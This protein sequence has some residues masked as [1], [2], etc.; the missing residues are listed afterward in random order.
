MR[1]HLLAA[2]AAVDAV[3]AG[4]GRA[5]DFEGQHLDFKEE[6]GTVR[7]GGRRVPVGPRE[8]Q[9]ARALAREACC[10]ANTADGGVLVVGVVDDR[11]GPT[12][13]VP[14]YLDLRWLRDRLNALT[15]PSASIGPIEERTVAGQ[16][17]YFVVVQGAMAE[18]HVVGE[19][20]LRT[21]V[22]RD[23]VELSGDDARRFL[24]FRRR[25]DWSENRSG[26]RLSRAVPAAIDLAMADYRQ[27][28]G[29]TPSDPLALV[30]QLGL[31]VDETDDPELNNAGALLLC[32]LDRGATQVQALFTRVEGAPAYKPL[33]RSAPLLVAFHDVEDALADAFRPEYVFVGPQ[34]R[35]LRAV[36][37][38]AFREA[39]V[40]A[41]MHRDYRI[42]NGRVDLLVTGDPPGALK[43]QSSGGFPPGVPADRLLTT[44]SRPRNPRLA[45]AL[46]TLGLAEQEGIGID[47]L[48][49]LM[50]RDGHPEPQIE[51]VGGDVVCYLHGGQVDRPV[52]DFFDDLAHAD[53][54]LDDDVRAHIAVTLLLRATPLRPE[55]LAAAA[56]CGPQEALYTLVRLE[57]AGA[58]ERLVNGS[59]SFRLTKES[60]AR[61]RSRLRYPSRSSLD[62]H[63]ELIRAYLDGHPDVG[64][65]RAAELLGVKQVMASRVLSQ[66][67][68]ERRVVEPVGNAR[69]PGVRYRLAS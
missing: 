22:G 29:R 31:T 51:E 38:R 18:T 12:A 36:P 11:T 46:H 3:L 55:A 37:R 26:Y 17:V 32:E 66:L 47:T 69:G 6:P 19:T 30:R 49:L 34:R 65:D 67:Y 27:E 8:E 41:L 68:N 61:L 52:R 39:L 56:Q 50:L 4:K 43:V 57:G 64:R 63:W 10:F 40:N 35:E 14:T 24:E 23:C 54:L 45:Q 25:Y 28:H 58:V 48:Y 9:A 15:F 7:S 13:F 1:S 44:P 2:H 16:R 62:E 59:R 33:R 20:A 21:R 42:P 60:R 53:P 5:E